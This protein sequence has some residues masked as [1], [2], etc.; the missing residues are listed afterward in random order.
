MQTRT[1]LEY[2]QKGTDQVSLQSV[3]PYSNMAQNW[4]I[5][6]EPLNVANS[7]ASVVASPVVLC[8]AVRSPH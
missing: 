2:V 8:L 4:P 3:C 7:E 1:I 6:N 5:N